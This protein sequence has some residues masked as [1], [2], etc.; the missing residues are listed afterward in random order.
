MKN[1][2]NQTE[3][4]SVDDK[5]SF[6]KQSLTFNSECDGAIKEKTR[7][8]IIRANRIVNEHR[9]NYDLLGKRIDP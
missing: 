8:D 2:R 4:S 1:C 3:V 9:K 6:H 5:S 7:K